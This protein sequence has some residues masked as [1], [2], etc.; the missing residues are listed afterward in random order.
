MNAEIISIGTELLIGS[1]LNTNEQFLSKQLAE[2]AIDVRRRTTVGDNLG[3]ICQCLEEAFLRADLVITSGGLGPTEDDVTVQSVSRFLRPPLILHKKTRRDIFQK[4]RLRGLRMTRRV[5]RQSLIPRGS[6]IFPNARGTAPGV[7]IKFFKNGQKKSLLLLPGPPGELEP[8]FLN[9]GLPVLKKSGAFP[10]KES[11]LTR[12]VKIAGLLEA[13]VAEKVPDLL[14]M[15]P[16]VT[17][18]IYAKPGEVE[19]VIMAKAISKNAAAK[20]IDAID[21]KI[22]ERFREKVIGTGPETLS[23][24]LGALLLKKRLTVAL[25]ES[26]S[27]GLLSSLLTETP[28]SSRYFLGAVVAY[29]NR[30]KNSLLGVPKDFLKKNGAVSPE[31]ASKLA[32]GVRER[33]LSDYGLAITGIAGPSGGTKKKPV[34]LVYIG[35]ASKTRVSVKKYLFLGE[36]S[37]VRRCAAEEAL[38]LL[39]LEVLGK[40]WKNE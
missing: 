33:L 28:G 38:N 4:M 14:K 30:I 40:F 22:R 31:V 11:F 10:K 32:Q 1:I 12:S 21:K 17:V 13:Q 18:G 23:S 36:R 27:G 16:P 8:L 24:A 3:R 2:L 5:E 39:R 9:H 35:L 7:F 29:D 19:L 6:Q 26:C 34:G 37:M 15:K 25:A 20:K